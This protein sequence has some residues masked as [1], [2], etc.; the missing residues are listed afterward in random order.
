MSKTV[1]HSHR[2]L[3]VP[4]I[5]LWYLSLPPILYLNITSLF[6][7]SKLEI[8]PEGLHAGWQTSGSLAT[9]RLAFNMFNGIR[10]RNIRNFY[11]PII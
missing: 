11:P 6:D 5:I 3:E 2:L 10:M 7:F 8:M 1:S 4:V 9:T